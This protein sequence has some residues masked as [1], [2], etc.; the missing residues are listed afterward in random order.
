MYKKHAILGLFGWSV[1]GFS[2]LVLA[3]FLSQNT[4]YSTS[5][6]AP[7]LLVTSIVRLFQD[8]LPIFIFQNKSLYKYVFYFRVPYQ[9]PSLLHFV[10]HTKICIIHNAHLF[11]DMFTWIANLFAFPPM[12]WCSLSNRLVVLKEKNVVHILFNCTMKYT[13]SCS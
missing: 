3:Y 11:W 5:Q 1:L 2:R 13:C 9:N 4:I 7:F 12:T 10:H 8:I 6:T